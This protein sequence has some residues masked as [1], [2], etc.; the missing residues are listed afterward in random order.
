MY[1][2]YY[3]WD[4]RIQCESKNPP[5]LATC[6][7]F[8]PNGWEFFNQILRAIMRYIANFWRSYAIL[9]ETTQRAFRSMVDILST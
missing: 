1:Q 4:D 6:S 8:F 7:N 2:L 3:T 9:S 5:A